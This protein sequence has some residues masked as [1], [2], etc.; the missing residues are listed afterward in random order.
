[1][2][3]LLLLW[4]GFAGALLLVTKAF[5]SLHTSTVGTARDPSRWSKTNVSHLKRNE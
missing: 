5:R 4:F 3:T 1:M 2:L